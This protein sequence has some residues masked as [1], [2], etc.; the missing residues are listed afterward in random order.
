MI[1]GTENSVTTSTYTN[2]SAVAGNY[3]I[4]VKAENS[5][6]TV[7]KSWTWTVGSSSSDNKVSVDVNPSDEK[8]RYLKESPRFSMSTLQT[9]RI[10]Q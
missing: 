6:G 4:E 2:S 7:S 9:A 1:Q 5:N 8:L 10:S 3:T